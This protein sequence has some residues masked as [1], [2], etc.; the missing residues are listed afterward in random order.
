MQYA[1]L[2]PLKERAKVTYDMCERR[3]HLEILH[4]GALG[5]QHA[6]GPEVVLPLRLGRLREHLW[7]R[8]G[9]YSRVS[10][11]VSVYAQLRDDIDVV[12]RKALK[13]GREYCTTAA[14][15]MNNLLFL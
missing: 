7:S 4:A 8:P 6:H 5:Y 3:T 9:V 14:K 13:R 15:T 11:S 2:R 1:T 12:V 10:V